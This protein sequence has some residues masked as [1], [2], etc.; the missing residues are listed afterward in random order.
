MHYFNMSGREMT[1]EPKLIIFSTHAETVA[2]LLRF[3]NMQVD[4]PLTPAPSSMVIFDYFEHYD[5]V[6]VRGRF[7][8]GDEELILLNMDA[9]D[10]QEMSEGSLKAYAGKMGTADM[11][12]V[13]QMPFEG[14]ASVSLEAALAFKDTLY[15]AFGYDPFA[16]AGPL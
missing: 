9:D 11:E 4:V 7:V 3:F 1:I 13:C 6:K 15:G 2:P 8:S 12:Q 5:R 10:F 16:V 14:P